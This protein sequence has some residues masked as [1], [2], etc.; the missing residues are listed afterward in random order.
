[1]R[2]E[3]SLEREIH[4]ETEKLISTKIY[5]S[6]ASGLM[7]INFLNCIFGTRVFDFYENE[8]GLNT[9][10]IAFVFIIYALWSI[11]NNPLIGYFVD[12]PRKFWSKYGKRFL[13][14]LIGGLFWSLSFAFLFVVPDLDPNKN[15][16]FLTFWLLFIL[17]I[18]SFLFSLY[19]VNYNSLIPD[20]FRTDK[21]R[22]SQS[23]FSIAFGVI[24][25]VLGAG[26]PP[27][28]IIYGDKGS[29]LL[30]AIIISTIGVALVLF[31]IPGI[32]EDHTM[33]ERALHID[34]QNESDSF[35]KMMKR[36]FKHRNLVAYLCLFTLI[37]SAVSLMI[38]SI[39]YI[40]RF[41]LNEEAIVESYLLLGFIITGLISVP[42][43]AKITKKLGDFKKTFIIATLLTVFLTIPFYFVNSLVFAIVSIALIGIGMIGIS[44]MIIPIFGDLLDEATVRNGIR[45]EGFYV[46]FRTIF[47]RISIIIQ[48]VT[49]AL[50]HLL[51]GFEPGSDTQSSRAII[52]LRIQVTIIPIILLLI[53]VAIFWKFYDL[54]P[55]KKE[56]IKKKLKELD[57]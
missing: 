19:D 1:M 34:A 7:M 25:T 23:S 24:G 12:K 38:A 8:V 42:I 49:F 20:K 45:Q 14:I 39:P 11:V 32:R 28:I 46:G 43:W 44:V 2:E 29:F 48:A 57:L 33:I 51:M 36:A 18:Y 5:I 35:I 10:M 53:G 47:A 50:I 41:L 21:Q 9:G 15:E 3:V 37:L 26:I 56:G 54:T 31:Q 4:I 17:C 6:S 40:V 55:E 22:L 16:L 52:G 27:L 30:M 13:W